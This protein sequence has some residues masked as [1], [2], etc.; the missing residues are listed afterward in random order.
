M[1]NER[2]LLNPVTLV[3]DKHTQ[4]GTEVFGAAASQLNFIYTE[5]HTCACYLTNMV[6]VS[7]DFQSN[8]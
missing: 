5:P 3:G 2:V 1:Y 7:Q 4:G 6:S 8:L